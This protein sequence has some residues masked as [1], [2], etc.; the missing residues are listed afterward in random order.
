MSD[1]HTELDALLEELLS[2]PGT[3]DEVEERIK[4]RFEQTRAVMALDL[5]GFS[6]TTQE[7]GI[8]AFLAFIHLMRKVARPIV[9][10]H[11]GV[12]VDAVADNILC[13]FDFVEDALGASR[14]L[15]TELR[16]DA[17]SGD[18][19]LHAS[20]AI[21]HGTI[22]NFG[23]VRIAGDEVNLASKLGEDIAEA[24]EILLTEGAAAELDTEGLTRRE[25]RHGDLDLVFYL[26]PAQPA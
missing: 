13:V 23:N 2:N 18:I 8:V 7:R 5:C 6:K 26:V 1:P 22:L 14:E 16:H 11:Q 3:E 19:E 20:V 17:G 25:L 21:G 12:I 15:V 4:R 24:D 9:E 10:R